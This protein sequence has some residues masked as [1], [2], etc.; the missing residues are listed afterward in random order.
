MRKLYFQKVTYS[1]FVALLVLASC[2]KD[3]FLGQTTTSNLTEE[4]VFKDSANTVGFLAG[5]YANVGFS[6]SASR[7]TYG[8]NALNQTPNGG[9]DA[10]SDEA[11]PFN[12]GGSTAVAWASGAI[13]AAVAT[14]DAY[15]TCYVNIRSVNQLLKNLPKTPINAFNKNL[16]KAEA[17]FLRAWYYAILLK[18]YGG[19]HLVGDSIYNYTD[20]IP[21]VRN[22]YEECVNYIVAECD[23]AG[24]ELPNAQVGVNY[25][26]AS[27]GSCLALKARVLLY[28]ASP[29][30]N[31]QSLTGTKNDLL[32]GY[33]GYN[34]ERWKAAADAAEAVI[35]LG[36]YQLYT[37]NATAPGYGFQFVF[38]KRYNTEYIFQLMRPSSNADLESLFQP[39]SR[40][41]KN[42][43]FPLQGLVDAF[44][45]RNGKAITD[46]TSGY[47]PQ[48][49]YANRDPRLDYTVVRDQTPMQN[50]LASGFSPVNI[51]QGIFNGVAT[52]QDAVHRGTV[53]GYYTNKMLS[54]NAVAND[55]T[56]PTERVLPLMRY[57]E[58]LLNYAEAS[59]EY[60]GPSGLVYTAVEAVRQRAGLNP[61]QLPAGLSQ[62]Q[63]REVIQNER[64]IELAF[65]EHRFWDVRRWKIAEQTDNIQTMGMEVNRNGAN[66]TYT[67]F[68][69]R[70][71][72]FRTAM[73]L[74]PIPQSEVAKSPEV[75][76]NPGY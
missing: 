57:A 34:K 8:P 25:G 68:P 26:R 19:V 37:D 33:S 52:G 27:R 49:P 65:E 38:T 66:V 4:T 59:N 35:G 16:M 14:N 42:G 20:A 61:Y 44:P 6:A 2:K 60:N 31:G 29:L 24:Q 71:R 7:F 17:R 54:P 46:P 10:S 64:R 75:I 3:G 30:F 47:D 28:A 15:K 48:N 55:F 73:Y 22:T 43:A 50:R 39:P 9:L 41:G 63:M 45:M 32:L 67:Q 69:V 36:A 18:H 11:E 12:T 21:A 76:Q 5:I 72:N 51:Y 62:V 13:N 56:H 58:V 23:A 40:T 74:W 1:F 70:K 53:T